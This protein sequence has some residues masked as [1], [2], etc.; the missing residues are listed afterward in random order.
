MKNTFFSAFKHSILRRNIVGHLLVLILFCTLTVGNL[1]WRFQRGGDGA[2]DQSLAVASLAVAQSLSELKGVPTQ[3]DFVLA[4]SI[5]FKTLDFD[6]NFN[7]PNNPS[8]NYFA[9]RALDPQGHELFRSPIAESMQFDP[10]KKGFYDLKHNGKNWR[11]FRNEIGSGKLV[12]ETALLS[13]L[14][15][16]DLKV[17]IEQF[18]FWPLVGFLPLAAII[19]WL[20]SVR[21]LR[22]LKDLASLI[23]QRTPNDMKPLK[24]K[25]SYLE[26]EPVVNEINSLLLKLETTLSRERA[27]LA[28]AAHELRTPLA[29]VQAQA[30]VLQNSL[31][32][33]DRI[34]ASEE[35]NIGVERTASLIAKLLTSAR[36]NTQDFSPLLLKTD[37]V[38]L[39]QERVA[40]FSVL[41]EKKNIEM[42][43]LAPQE[44]MVMMDRDSFLSAIDN[45][46]DNAIRY[47]PIGASIFVQISAEGAEHV[48]LT[49]TDQGAGIPEALHEQVFER[50]FRVPGTEQQGSGLGLA[51]VKHVMELHRGGITLIKG[52]GNQGLCVELSVPKASA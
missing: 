52:K 37:L 12:I 31:T 32:D 11:V 33:Q 38:S 9:L 35:L 3:S 48:R 6:K 22:P 40:T 5:M 19:T 18:V 26:T 29:V 4:Y 10:S 30:H 14:F 7:F 20:T 25:T 42:E 47:S 2:Y 1:A 45:V 24:L 39:V 27:F 50:F 41:A 43:L 49:V 15:E 17:T 8:K 36:L 16:N 13:E 46:I 44:C 28:D 21:G 51:I 23:A 34:V